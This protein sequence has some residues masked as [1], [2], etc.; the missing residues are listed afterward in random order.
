MQHKLVLEWPVRRFSNN[1][2]AGNDGIMD[3]HI[4]PAR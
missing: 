1:F 2:L 4:S 3:V